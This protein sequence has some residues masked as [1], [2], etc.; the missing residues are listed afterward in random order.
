MLLCY[1]TTYQR[2]D[3]VSATPD[4]LFWQVETDQEKTAFVLINPSGMAGTAGRP[5]GEAGGWQVGNQADRK[6][7]RR[8]SR[9]VSGRFGT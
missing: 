2:E 3:L 6:K 9:W 1:F 5:E 4:P 8:V 7:K